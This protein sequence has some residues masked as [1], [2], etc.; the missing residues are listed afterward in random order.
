MVLAPTVTAEGARAGEVEP[1][2]VLELP[3]ATATW[4]PALVSWW[5]HQMTWWKGER[6]EKTDRSDSVIKSGGGTTTERHGNDT[7][8]SR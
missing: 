5:K 8:T 4:T 3:A 7:R 2:S 6:T 1:A